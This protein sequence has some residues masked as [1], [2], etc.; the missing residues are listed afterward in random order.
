MVSETKP[1]FKGTTHE[2]DCKFYHD[3]LSQ[4]TAKDCI[5]WMENKEYY[6][7]WI[8]PVNGLHK[9]FEDLKVYVGCPVGNSPELMNCD[10]SLNKDVHE[11]V[12][13][14][15]TATSDFDKEDERKF[16]LSTPKNGA[17]VYLQILDPDTG[18]CPSSARIMQDTEKV[19]LALKEIHGNDGTIIDD[20]NNRPGRR[21]R[22]D[23]QVHRRGGYKPRK[24]GLCMNTSSRCGILMQVKVVLSRS[25]IRSRHLMG[26]RKIILL[27]QN[28]KYFS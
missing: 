5:A 16:S 17:D 11:C 14:H 7:M 8:L 10:S 28:K 19:I 18:I 23:V 12:D 15:I 4:M 24:L 26:A 13:R 20:I 6:N 22:H 21:H 3:A 25:R 9:D 1:V 27:R 2:H